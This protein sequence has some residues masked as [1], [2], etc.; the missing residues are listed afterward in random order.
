VTRTAVETHTAR[1]TMPVALAL[2]LVI[3]GGALSAGQSRIN[4]ELGA[5]IGSSLVAAVVSF[6]SGLV[7]VTGLLLARPAGR[8]A[9]RRWREYGL[10]WWQ[11]LGGVGGAAF[12]FVAAY[13]VPILG[14][15]LMS[16]AQVT[17]QITGALVADRLGLSPSGRQPLSV[18]RV[19]GA[20]LGA[21]AVVIS[22]LGRPSGDLD[23]VALGLAVAAGFGMSLQSAVNGRLNQA[24]GDPLVATTVNF[25]VG[26]VALLLGLA[27]VALGAGVQVGSL[28]G[29][30]WLYVGGVAGIVFVTLN[31]ITVPVLG[32]LRLGLAAVAGQLAGALLLDA[33]VPGGPDVTLSLAV[34]ALLTVVAVAVAGMRPRPRRGAA[35]R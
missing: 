16:V 5:R 4:A 18:P 31:V 9:L 28:P 35:S 1:H 8:R 13:T 32:V 19:A 26:T 33:L 11:Y 29:D 20:V 24:A 12:V 23:V 3:A 30:W 6:A 22:A 2:T 25:V 17:G 21:V 7:V 14:V 15:G 10:R 34:G 27:V